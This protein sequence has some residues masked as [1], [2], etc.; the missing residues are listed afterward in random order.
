MSDQ[1]QTYDDLLADGWQPDTAKGVTTSSYTSLSLCLVQDGKRLGVV[2]G[3]GRTLTEAQAD[4][5]AEAAK[6]LRRHEREEGGDV[7]SHRRRN[8]STKV[9]TGELPRDT[10]AGIH[11]PER[12]DDPNAQG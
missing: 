11:H 5:V 7:F 9:R 6:W 2:Q 12:P 10:A 1:H 4:V 8:R 3:Y